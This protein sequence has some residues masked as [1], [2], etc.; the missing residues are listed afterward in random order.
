M[1]GA[2]ETILLQ[3]RRPSHGEQ[4]SFA[5]RLVDAAGTIRQRAL[6]ASGQVVEE[7]VVDD[8]VGAGTTTST[9]IGET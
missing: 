3:L 2:T 9:P 5:R 6:S 1:A 4:I 7:G 8:D